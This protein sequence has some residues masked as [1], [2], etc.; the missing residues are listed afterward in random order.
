MQAQTQLQQTN[1]LFDLFGPCAIHDANPDI[2]QTIG[3]E[4]EIAVAPAP[5]LAPVQAPVAEAPRAR[6]ISLGTHLVLKVKP[7][8]YDAIWKQ[9]V[10]HLSIAY[11]SAHLAEQL[12]AKVNDAEEQSIDTFYEIDLAKPP[13]DLHLQLKEAAS[14]LIRDMHAH[15]CLYFAKDTTKLDIPADTLEKKCYPGGSED[16]DDDDTIY[17]S[18]QK[19][20]L[21][22]KPQLGWNWLVSEFGEGKG[23]AHAARKIANDFIKQLGLKHREPCHKADG[24]LIVTMLAWPDS[25]WHE[26][27]SYSCSSRDSLKAVV[28]RTFHDWFQ[29]R[30]EQVTAE[31]LVK[32]F[33]DSPISAW[34]WDIVSRS[35]LILTDD[36][37][38]VFYQRKVEFVMK[39]KLAEQFQVFIAEYGNFD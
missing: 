19:L 3:P 15:A 28:Q 12:I 5:A 2:A 8:D 23:L 10:D 22:F 13:T 4:S 30:E 1:D 34:N 37:T 27:T 7:H 31:T 9:I 29:W 35:K 11:R 18:R 38:A 36:L 16:E 20:A 21:S 33:A 14:K 32:A 24:T 6:R 39:P 17:E 26:R 25:T